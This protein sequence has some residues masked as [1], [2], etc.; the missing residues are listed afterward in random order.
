MGVLPTCMAALLVCLVPMEAIGVY[1]IPGTGFTDSC[2]FSHGYWESNSGP[3]E[4]AASPLNHWAISRP[5]QGSIL[6]TVEE[7]E[8][9]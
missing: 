8:V 5:P 1:Q 7:I 3:L 4:K 9:N 2:K 6:T